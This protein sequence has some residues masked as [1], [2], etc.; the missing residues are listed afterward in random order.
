MEIAFTEWVPVTDASSV[1][2]VRRTALSA[3]HRLGFDE[4]RSGELALLA[5]EASRNILVHGEAVRSCSLESI[6]PAD[7]WRASSRW[8]AVP[9]SRTWLKPW[10]TATRHRERWGAG[11]ER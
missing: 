1:G 10:P 5:T 8:I 9:A 3:A 2:E 11:L 6:K 7:R 4:T